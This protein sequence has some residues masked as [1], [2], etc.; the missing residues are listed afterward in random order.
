MVHCAMGVSRST[1]LVLAYL[2]K[3]KHLTLKQAYEMVSERRTCVGPNQGFWRQLLEYEKHLALSSFPLN[4]FYNYLAQMQQPNKSLEQFLY[5]SRKLPSPSSS[6]SLKTP[7]SNCLKDSPTWNANYNSPS[8]NQHFT[9][10]ELVSTECFSS[11][12]TLPTIE[13]QHNSASVERLR[14]NHRSS[15]Y[16]TNSSSSSSSSSSSIRTQEIQENG[17]VSSRESVSF[18]ATSSDPTSTSQF[19]TSKL[20]FYFFGNR[21]N[22]HEVHSKSV[23][24]KSPERK[25]TFAI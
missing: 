17:V 5:K 15:P 24:I 14:S 20:F 19:T 21:K 2:I 25:Y 13:N 9:N 22:L 11:G 7:S 4:T 12:F 16:S 10:K 23:N 1:S 8:G 6:P 18:T 3:H